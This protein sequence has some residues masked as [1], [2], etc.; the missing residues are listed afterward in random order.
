MDISKGRSMKHDG[1]SRVEYEYI[2]ACK[3]LLTTLA[4]AFDG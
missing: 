1:E 2:S 3:Y 4:L